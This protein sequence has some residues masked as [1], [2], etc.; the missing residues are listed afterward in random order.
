VLSNLH[1]KAVKRLTQAALYDDFGE[2]RDAH[3]AMYPLASALL[4]LATNP[5]PIKTAMALRGLC[6]EELRL[7]MCPM[8]RESR[9]KLARLLDEQPLD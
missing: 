4:S 1:P 2:A 9:A 6:A 8:S 7:P 3:R 5:I